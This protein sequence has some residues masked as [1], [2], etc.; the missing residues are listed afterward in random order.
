MQHGI[1]TDAAAGSGVANT[2][3]PAFHFIGLHLLKPILTSLVSV[4]LVALSEGRYANAPASEAYLVQGATRDFDDYLRYGVGKVN[5]SFM[6]E[7]EP[8]LRGKRK[9]LEAGYYTPYYARRAA[10]HA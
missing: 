4:G 2:V 9:P 1:N 10:M 5:Y 7:L 3:N 6:S 8:A